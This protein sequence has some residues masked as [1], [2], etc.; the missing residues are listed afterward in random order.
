MTNQMRTVG[1]LMAGALM[2]AACG[3]DQGPSADTDFGPSGDAGEEAV[4][5]EDFVAAIDEFALD[6]VARRVVRDHELPGA[7]LQ[8]RVDGQKPTTA[9]A[10]VADLETQ[11]ELTDVDQFRIYSVTKAVTAIVS[12]QLAEEGALSLDDTAADLLP[13]SVV[14]GVPNAELMT[15]RQLLSHSSGAADYLDTVRPGEELPAFVGELFAQ[16]QSGSWHWYSPQELIDFSSQFDPTF[17]PGESVAYSNTGYVM[18]GLIIEATTGNNLDD[19]MKARVFEPLGLS[20][21]YLETKNSPNDYVTGYHVVGDGPLASLTG[22]NAS[23][24]WA[25]GGVISNIHDF[26]RLADAIFEGELLTPESHDEMLTFTPGTKEGVAY[27]MGIYQ[28][29]TPW[30]SLELVEGGAAGF[31]ASAFRFPEENAT[32]V[33]LFNRNEA[34]AAFGFVVE[35]GLELIS[36]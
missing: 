8:I 4:E 1:L 13:A 18:L 17:P 27:G 12:L 6:A 10:G 30:G 32:I 16:A 9:A 15:V 33:G 3:D 14:S 7:A 24:A 28:V 19:E 25:A 26:G 31:T 36:P 29:D 2:A 20:A 11:R 23:F 5:D 21:T 35:A 34:Q 22:S